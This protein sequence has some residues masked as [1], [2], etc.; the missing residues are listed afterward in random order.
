M[1][2]MQKCFKYIQVCK[3]VAMTVIEC[4]LETAQS[5]C[6]FKGKNPFGKGFAASV[7]MRTLKAVKGVCICMINK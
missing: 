2:K 6:T 5:N 7:V 4:K 1:E 3:W